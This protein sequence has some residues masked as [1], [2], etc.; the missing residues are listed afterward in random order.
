[1]WRHSSQVSDGSA[2]EGSLPTDLR[3]SMTYPSCTSP[4]GHLYWDWLGLVGMLDDAGIFLP[5]ER[6]YNWFNHN[7][8]GP[9][10]ATKRETVLTAL[11]R[12][13][14]TC[15]GSLTCRRH[16]G[17]SS[18]ALS[19]FHQLGSEGA[20]WER[21]QEGMWQELSK[22]RTFLWYGDIWRELLGNTSADNVPL[23]GR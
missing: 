7:H 5:K 21:S 2:E 13:S 9:R 16:L 14:L 11:G 17:I 19:S 6:P 10:G 18:E 23:G 3:G 8:F 1:M 12:N 4:A 20:K 22:M 15:K